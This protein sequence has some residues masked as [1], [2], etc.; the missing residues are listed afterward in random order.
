MQQEMQQI[1][2]NFGAAASYI[3]PEMLKIGGAKIDQFI[4]AD[5]RL[6]VYAFYLHDIVRRA[7]H[8]LSDAEEK[9]LADAG[10]LGGSASNIYNILA[11]A[12]FPYPR[13]K[14]SDR[15]IRV[16][17]A[18][19]GAM[20]TSPNREDRKLAM[21]S[22]FGALGAFSRT[23]GTTMNSEVQKVRF[24]AKS[25]KY[26]VGSRAGARRAEH[27][28]V[29][30]HAADRR[31]EQEPADV[32]SLSAPAQADDGD[33]RPAALLRPVRA[34][35]ERGQSQIHAGRSGDST[36]SRR[37]SRSAPTTPTVVQNA[38]NERWVDFYPTEGKQSGAYSNGGAY[39]VHPFMLLNYLGEYN[40]VSTLAHEL[41]HTMH[42]YYSNKTQPYPTASYQTFVA[43]VAST[44]NEALLMDYMLKQ[45]KDKPTRLALLG[46]YL[47]N[48]KA[49][50][51]RQT[52]FA[53]F[54]L[55]MHEIAEKDQPITG[56][57][58]R[59][60]VPRHHPALLR[61]QE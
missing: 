22:F 33:H 34:A 35:G 14:F 8:T 15:E 43:E 12:D 38:F 60:A 47:E 1:Y 40:D 56:D 2:A 17:Q 50:V 41:G 55:R 3:E 25:R 52:Q 20:R 13:V 49:T 6:K 30:L 31:R 51:F 4:A 9:I 57:D 48:A 36:S 23:F 53:E 28:D 44:F 7:P 61:R 16:D 42:S 59:Q 39:D 26:R 29:G 27:S 54:E 19:Y 32:P 46:N 58:A 24:Y 21:S 45:I 37:S 18:N 5:P 10:P 11:N